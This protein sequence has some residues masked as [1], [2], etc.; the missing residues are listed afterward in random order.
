MSATL[1]TFVAE[2]KD[3]S[4]S[5]LDATLA[6]LDA[7][8]RQARPRPFGDIPSL[9]F[10]SIVVFDTPGFEPLLVFESNFDGE[11]NAYLDALLDA[12][13]EDLQ[14][15]FECCVGYSAPEADSRAYLA[16]FLRDHVVRPSAYHVGN[17]A[18]RQAQI[19]RE[20]ALRT[21][22]DRGIDCYQRDGNRISHG[23]SAYDLIRR[24]VRSNGA[25]DW[26][27]RPADTGVLE[28][29]FAWAR[30]I[31]VLLAPFLIASA[32]WVA[33]GTM[34]LVSVVGTIAALVSLLA[35][36][37][38]WHERRDVPMDPRSFDPRHD[39][40]LGAHEDLQAQNH[41]ASI[42]VV[43]GGRFRRTTL[44]VVLWVTNLFARV[45][46][47][48]R[49]QGIPS[50][51]FAQWSLVNDGKLLLFLSNY[52][53]AW[54][55]YLDDFVDLAS[56]GLTAIWSN[57]VG[58]PRTR[59]LVFGGARDRVAFKA[60]ARM[61]QT[62]AAVWY[63][64]Y[65]NLSVQQIDSNSVVRNGLATPPRG[66]DLT[67]WLRRLGGGDASPSGAPRA[68]ELRLEDLGEDR[69]PPGEALETNDIQGVVL[70]SY[71]RLPC[72]CYVVLSVRD[73]GP[74]RAWLAARLEEVTTA[75]APREIKRALQM[76]FTHDGLEALGLPHE[77][78]A[79]F[80]PTFVD[81]MASE[82]Y[83][84]LL[85]D[86]GKNA[87]TAWWWGGSANPVHVLLMFYAATEDALDRELN[88]RIRRDLDGLRVERVLRAG[89][90]PTDNRE[91][92]GFVDGVGQPVIAGSGSARHQAKRT[93]HVTVIPAGEILLG[94]KNLDSVRAPGPVLP[95]E[96][97]GYDTLPE[98][99]REPRYTHRRDLGR[100]GTY[101]V[102]RQLEQDVSGFWQ[103]VT[104]RAERLYPDDA[105]GPTRLAAKM[106]G[107]WP[108]GA[109]LV[110]HPKSD[111]ARKEPGR[112]V[113]EEPDND[114]A[115]AAD[116]PDGLRCP[117]GAHIRRANP[118][119]AL[120]E[121]PKTARESV[122]RRRLMRR[123]RSYGHRNND[124]LKEDGKERG[125]FFICLN[126][127]LERQFV[128][129]QHTWVNNRGFN[130]L[131]GEVD[132]LIGRHVED[133]NSFTVPDDPLRWR[134]PDLQSFVT[135]RGGAFWFLPGLTALAVILR[136]TTRGDHVEA[137]GSD[138]PIA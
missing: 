112:P 6:A 93:G 48:G 130:A 110:R 28:R 116:D 54:S 8:V 97:E 118:R 138:R 72:S 25:F 39:A 102:F 96:F 74:A 58:F 26:A 3:G 62:P 30:L 11:L 82:R 105:E 135:M 14:R 77:T 36:A 52:D 131:H 89:R 122:N 69:A 4:R 51:H 43:K 32:I 15:V 127:D 12:A 124:P 103:A 17:F 10:A 59:F 98:L 49:L 68:P 55:A 95:A 81:G 71:S 91:H 13:A 5:R 121:N 109:P 107:R 125:L 1:L 21:A 47:K 70:S 9:H 128:F 104:R 37:L 85:G 40:K 119:D 88:D 80:S 50:I 99:P 76:A 111:P 132:P 106:V 101:L 66:D 134:V 60:F 45:S 115:F 83:A 78:L 38:G 42:T 137:C 18:R 100:N 136:R 73:A 29:F 63:S 41:L 114:F 33:R 16:S 113:K 22:V 56:S 34:A 90:Q 87:P 2:V 67:T 27:F 23:D 53:G 35:L 79:S 75:A 19:Q 126:A 31:G 20:R 65:P 123:G 64:A 57:T 92:F 120:G 7:Q 86:L 24:V 46:T 44:R 117:F 108:S 61:Q 84:R 133:S 94:Y 129:V